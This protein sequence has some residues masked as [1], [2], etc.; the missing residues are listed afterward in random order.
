MLVVKK[1]MDE[2]KQQVGEMNSKVSNIRVN[3]E[4]IEYLRD[5]RKATL[6]KEGN[7][8]GKALMH[9]EPFPSYSPLVGTV[10]TTFKESQ[11]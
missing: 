7:D 1:G 8:K 6:V 9:S 4:A 10:V 5:L 2:M 3:M 11:R